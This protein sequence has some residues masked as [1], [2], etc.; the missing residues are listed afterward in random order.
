MLTG[1]ESTAEVDAEM[2]AMVQKKYAAAY[3]CVLKI[4]EFVESNYH[5]KV[6]EDEKF[7]L[8]IHIAKVM[9]P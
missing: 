9:R 2:S 1:Q 4:A 7:Y 3:R 6:N 5:Y 8:M